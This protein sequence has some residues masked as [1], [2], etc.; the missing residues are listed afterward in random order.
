[1]RPKDHKFC[2]LSPII[3]DNPRAPQANGKLEKPQRPQVGLEEV[4][5]VR[6]RS[7]C[8]PETWGTP[9][10]ILI[11]RIGSTK[12]SHGCRVPESSLAVGHDT[13]LDLSCLVQEFECCIATVARNL[14][15][16]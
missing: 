15:R 8:P 1:M 3:R 2:P 6:S 10:R 11:E 4:T 5:R 14:S 13:T 16:S 7:H 12:Q 9:L